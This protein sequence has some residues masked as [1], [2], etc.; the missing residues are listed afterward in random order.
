M[1][2]TLIKGSGAQIAQIAQMPL[3]GDFCYLC[4]L[5]SAKSKEKYISGKSQKLIFGR[6]VFAK[7][8]Q[9]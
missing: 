9:L 3:F 7:L 4:D 2:K 6:E 1:K 5:C 8:T